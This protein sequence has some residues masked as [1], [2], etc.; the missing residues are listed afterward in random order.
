MTLHRP[1]RPAFRSH[2][3]SNTAPD[4]AHHDG[5][6]RPSA[7]GVFLAV[8]HHDRQLT[9]TQRAVLLAVVAYAAGCEGACW[10]SQASVAEA[11]SLS[12]ST[13][14]RALRALVVAGI[15][16]EESAAAASRRRRR[17]Q[18]T[19]TYRVSVDYVNGLTM[20]SSTSSVTVTEGVCHSDRGGSVTVREAPTLK[21]KTGETISEDD[22]S[23]VVVIDPDPDP[24]PPDR[25]PD[26]TAEPTD[27]GAFGP[28]DAVDHHQ[29]TGPQEAPQAIETAPAASEPPD[30][31]TAA[32]QPDPGD[33]SDVDQVRARWDGTCRESLGSRPAR[34]SAGDVEAAERAIRV[35]GLD[36]VLAAVDELMAGDHGTNLRAKLQA[37]RHRGGLPTPCRQPAWFLDRHVLEYAEA[38]EDAAARRAR[39]ELHAVEDDLAHLVADEPVWTVDDQ[40][41]AEID[42]QQAAA[43]RPCRRVAAP[44]ASRA[45]W[46]A[47]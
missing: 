10:A 20:Q 16:L 28:A 11:T 9:H 7:A 1:S 4:Q 5:G 30:E 42:A 27:P 24:R 41:E 23:R 39:V 26:P 46:G 13:V 38:H 8:H 25:P 45:A 6:D 21:E 3:N 36:R 12:V 43:P 32:V 33:C 15:L 37:G 2:V 31:P 19:P 17:L 34:W 35:H 40:A 44:P 22:E 47:R 14:G 29:A 18:S